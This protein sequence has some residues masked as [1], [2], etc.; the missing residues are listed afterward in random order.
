[1]ITYRLCGILV[2]LS[3]LSHSNLNAQ[4]ILAD[5]TDRS[6]VAFAQVTDEKGNTIGMSDI[7]GCVRIDV[8]DGQVFVIKHLSYEPKNV[9]ISHPAN[10]DTLWLSP[11]NYNLNEVSVS[12][13][14]SDYIHLKAY[15]RSYQQN[16]SCLKYFKDGIVHY[17]IP[18]HGK[19][20]KRHVEVSR[21]LE[22]KGLIAKDRKRTNSVV[23]KYI[24]TPY[25]EEKTLFERI[26]QQAD[27]FDEGLPYAKLCMEGVP[28]GICKQDSLTRRVEYDALALEGGKRE[29]KL[30]GYTTRIEAFVQ[31]EIYRRRAEYQSYIDLLSHRDYR[32]IFYKYK[33]DKHEQL[34]EVTDELYVLSQAYVT[35]EEMK[36]ALKEERSSLKSQEA[37][38]QNPAI[39]PIHE[40]LQSVLKR[41]LLPAE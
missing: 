32:K 6:V 15:F 28:A 38:W 22:N 24:T 41:E 7:D 11:A 25:L 10:G 19:K 9:K 8:K 1:M 30:F 4:I 14:Q 12:A 21:L 39:P 3:A 17:Y 5:K 40:Y 2:A 16:D 29:G 33:K 13:R 20:V 23:D 36:R 27:T 37:Y 31:T 34:V 18:L 35:S 26:K